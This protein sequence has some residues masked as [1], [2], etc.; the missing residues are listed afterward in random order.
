MAP[1]V[2]SGCV[3]VKAGTA[4]NPSFAATDGNRCNQPSAVDVIFQ[5]A[6]RKSLTKDRSD[7][8]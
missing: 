8:L 7:E 4:G 3:Y 5:M 1:T 2:P 6:K